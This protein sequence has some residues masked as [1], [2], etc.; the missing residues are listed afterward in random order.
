MHY[1]LIIF[2]VTKHARPFG[3]IGECSSLRL[4]LSVVPQYVVPIFRLLGELQICMLMYPQEPV[5]DVK[6]YNSYNSKVAIHVC[7]KRID[8]IKIYNI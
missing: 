2:V 6:I 7:I 1:I 4:G 8:G 3:A 5:D